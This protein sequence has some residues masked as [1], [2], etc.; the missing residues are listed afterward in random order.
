MKSK[1]TFI[2]V[3]FCFLCCVMA[4]GQQQTPATEAIA[5]DI[6]GVVKGGT[7]VQI[8]KSDFETTVNGPVALPD[9]SGLLICEYV[10]GS[11]PG[12]NRITKIDNRDKASTFVENSHGALGLGFDSKGRLIANQILPVER[13]A[14]GVIYPKGQEAVFADNFEGKPFALTNDI[15][16]DKKGGV[17]LT[18][19]KPTESQVSAGYR[20]LESAV[21]YIPPGGKAIKIADGI[22]RPNGIQLSPDEKILYVNNSFGDYLLAFDVQPDGTVRNRRDFAKYE[23]GKDSNADGLA[24]DGEGRLYVVARNGVQVFSPQGQHLGTIPAVGGNVAFAGPGKKTLYIT[25]RTLYKVQ[26]LAQGFKG[27]A[28]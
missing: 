5:P 16:V 20:P 7:K 26:M 14:L 24:I 11:G 1:A 4:F 22:G 9:G 18:D 8:V 23:T 25:G 2:V 13:P 28:K 15:V 17:Y 3:V 12:V 19:P 10:L 6:P 27:R 21:Y